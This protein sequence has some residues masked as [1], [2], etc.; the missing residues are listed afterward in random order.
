M[1]QVIQFDTTVESGF[2]RIPEQY[3][4]AI[5][6]KVQVTVMP[7]Q[8]NLTEDK[9]QHQ[10]ARKALK[11]AFK[12]AQKQSVINGTDDIS[13]SEIDDIIKECRQEASV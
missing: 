9:V 1:Q 7:I 4:N 13:M 11:D 3:I 6:S 5:S 10:K 12:A 8:L 2:I